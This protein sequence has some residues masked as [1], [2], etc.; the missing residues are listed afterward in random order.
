[1][2]IR[3]NFLAQNKKM[4]LFFSLTETNLSLKL[5]GKKVHAISKL[6]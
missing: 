6:T 1:M 2:D 5:N 3:V 4:N